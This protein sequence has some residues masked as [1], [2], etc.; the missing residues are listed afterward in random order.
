MKLATVAVL[1]RNGDKALY[2]I[3]P[4]KHSNDLKNKQNKVYQSKNWHMVSHAA[5]HGA[6]D[7]SFPPIIPA[8]ISTDYLKCKSFNHVSL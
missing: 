1:N 6:A 7:S 4:L 5:F 8:D 3:L 2:E